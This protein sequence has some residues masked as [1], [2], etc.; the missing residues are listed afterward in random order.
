MCPTWQSPL[1]RM[2]RSFFKK[3]YFVFEMFTLPQCACNVI[4]HTLY[5]FSRV[6]R[7]DKI[8]FSNSEKHEVI[9]A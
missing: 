5:A 4:Q 8:T 3:I 6:G 2:D 7:V 9:H 1:Y